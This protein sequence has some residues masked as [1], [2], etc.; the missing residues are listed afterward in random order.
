MAGACDKDDVEAPIMCGKE[1]MK[2]DSTIHFNNAELLANLDR[3]R[4]ALDQLEKALEMVDS[5]P[6]IHEHL[7]DAYL[8]KGDDQKALTLFEKSYE[9]KGNR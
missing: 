9:K 1:G 8:L 4:E 6:V 5:D 3:K 7:G 2:L